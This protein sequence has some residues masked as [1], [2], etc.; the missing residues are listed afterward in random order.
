MSTRLLVI[1]PQNDFCDVP[2]ELYGKAPGEQP[3]LAVPGAHANMVTLS[4]FVRAH[5]MHVDEVAVTLDSH[6]FVGIERP[7]FWKTAEGGEV[8]PFTTIKLADVQAGRFLPRDAEQLPAVLA[9]LEQLQLRARYDLT[10][11]PVHCVIGTWGHQVHPFV[12][13]A[14]GE[15]ER[16]KQ[17]A[18]YMV[19]KG[20]NPMTEHYSAVAAEVTVPEDLESTYRNHKLI[21]WA[22]DAHV[23]LV[24]GE[25]G[26]HCVK[27]TLDDLLSMA[28]LRAKGTEVIVLEDCIS[29]VPGFEK[30]YDD[31]LA[32]LAEEGVHRMT[33]QEAAVFLEN[34]AHA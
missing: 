28:F 20:T 30:N 19:F 4:R 5:G 21:K 2:A 9:Y 18:S 3:A 7:T 1:D 15:W 26:S 6:H 12:L 22:A 13:K 11:W 16:A 27:A 14:L 34:L 10:V 25:A 29:P 31:W 33:T 23:L 24:A 32:R 17:K 8:A